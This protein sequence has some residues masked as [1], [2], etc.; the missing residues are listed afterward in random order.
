[1]GTQDCG[2]LCRLKKR[3]LGE[4]LLAGNFIEKTT[5]DKA[6]LAQKN[7]NKL[8]G[9][10]LVDLG[11]IAQDELKLVLQFQEDLSNPKEA[12]K[13]AGGLR[14]KFG[15]LLLEVGKI[16]ETQLDEALS[17]QKITG[18][19]IGEIL[20]EKGYINEKELKAILFFQKTQEQKDI[21]KKFKLG[22]LLVSLNIITRKQL[23]QAL[24]IQKLNPEKKLGEILIQLGY[25]KNEDIE[26]GLTL[27]QKLATIALSTLIAFSSSFFINEVSAN[28][29]K[30]LK[31]AKGIVRITAE[32]KSFAKLNL[33][34]Q[35]ND[36]I[37]TESHLSKGVLEIDNA[38]LLDIKT[39][40]KS[41]F[42]VFEGFGDGI[43]EEVEIFGF[44]Q[45]VKIGPNGGMIL[46]QNLPKS[47]QYN[48]SYK[49]KISQ[50]A[51]IGTYAWPYSISLTTY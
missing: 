30:E 14:K 25:A 42:I 18:K 51:R 50:K 37:I 27:Q 40:T 11:A 43:I 16:N 7:T 12:I 22:E 29:I 31:Q 23:E 36:L 32:V 41:I 5:L 47:I 46:L 26:K 9:E 45:P 4:L 39:N 17:I 35:I 33:V 10:L 44:E 49:F 34:K 1:M 20:V 48:L 13:F 38:T 19:K 6:L 3:L 2:L 24:H 15:E 21:P 28:D 8:L